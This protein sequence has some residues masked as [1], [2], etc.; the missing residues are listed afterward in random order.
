MGNGLSIAWIGST[1]E[2]SDA[3]VSKIDFVKAVAF[4]RPDGDGLASEGFP[5]TTRFAFE[6][7]PPCVPD[8]AQ[9]V[10]GRVSKGSTCSL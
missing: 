1:V 5:R 7:D 6:G 9:M 8:F 2:R 4:G 10:A 3:L